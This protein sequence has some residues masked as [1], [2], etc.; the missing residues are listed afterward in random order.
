MSKIQYLNN[1]EE[2][3]REA[4]LQHLRA[5]AFQQGY[6]PGEIDDIFESAEQASGEEFRDELLDYG[7]EVIIHS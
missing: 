7:I 6:A 5:A 3:S 2:I 1:G 4:A